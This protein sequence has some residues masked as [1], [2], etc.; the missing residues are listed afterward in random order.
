MDIDYVVMPA[1]ILAVGILVIWLS[2]RRM[3]SLS[4]KHHRTWR[5]VTERIVLSIIALL[6]VAVAGTSA[7]NAIALHHF[8]ALNPAPGAFYAVNG[9]RMHIYCMGNGSPTIVL[10]AGGG[11]DSVIW[12][13]VQPALS[14]TTRVCAY[15]RAGS[16][17]SD[18]LSSPRDADRIADE[19]HQLLPLAG[20]TGPIVLMGHSIGGIFIRDYTTRYPAGVAGLIFVDS[21]TPFQNRNPALQSPEA[22]DRPHGSLIWR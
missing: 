9:H 22:G 3:R 6:A 4:A 21:S 10:E 20:I 7:F 1:I 5:K 13:G 16:G 11:N 17:W 15:D 19:L 2:V 14:K 8:W 12:R 18:A